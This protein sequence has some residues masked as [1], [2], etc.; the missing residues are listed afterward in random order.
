MSKPFVPNANPSVFLAKSAKEKPPNVLKPKPEESV[1]GGTKL[2]ITTC[3]C[4][5][6]YSSHFYMQDYSRQHE[7]RINSSE[8]TEKSTPII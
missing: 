6:S 2:S 3:R 8:A 7:H 5:V 1:V 4:R